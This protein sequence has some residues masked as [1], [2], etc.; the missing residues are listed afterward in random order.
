MCDFVLVIKKFCSHK[1]CNP[2]RS[3]KFWNIFIS[4]TDKQTDCRMDKQMDGWTDRQMN[5]RT[6]TQRDG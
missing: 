3:A 4:F 5:R 2:I 1:I 6:D